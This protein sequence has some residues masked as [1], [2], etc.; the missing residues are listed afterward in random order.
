[1]TGRIT[2]GWGNGLKSKEG[3]FRLGIGEVLYYENGEVRCCNSCP[4]KLWMPHP[5]LEVLTAT[6]DGEVGSLGWYYV[7]VGSSACS[8][9]GLRAP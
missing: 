9:G 2:A 8:G 3:R 5:S 7:E 6:L 1:M 4:E